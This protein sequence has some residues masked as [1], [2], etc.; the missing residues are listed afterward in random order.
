M[1]HGYATYIYLY[2]Y[3]NFFFFA[4]TYSW[5]LLCRVRNCHP[6]LDYVGWGGGIK[7]PGRDRLV[8]FF[9]FHMY[10]GMY[11]SWK[12]MCR[13]FIII[14]FCFLPYD[15]NY[16]LGATNYCLSPPSPFPPL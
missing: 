9:S 14:Y 15:T 11:V 7:C 1:Q 16:D 13:C 10:R 3:V 8:V 6:L 2:I 4:K 12:C 5:K